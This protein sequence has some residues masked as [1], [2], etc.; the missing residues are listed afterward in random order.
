VDLRIARDD[1]PM[2]RALLTFEPRLQLHLVG[3]QL[4]ETADIRAVSRTDEVRQHVH[5]AERLAQDGRRRGRMGQRRPVGTG[6]FAASHRLAPQLA[7]TILGA[8]LGE[9]VDGEL[10]P[11][12][13]RLVQQLGGVVVARRQGHRRAMQLVIGAVRWC[14]PQLLQDLAQ[15]AGREARADDR[16]VQVGVE[17]PDFRPSRGSDGR[18]RFVA[19]D[20]SRRDRG[21][22]DEGLGDRAW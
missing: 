15:F 4:A 6:D 7:H 20:Q 8:D 3:L 16:T 12:V 10:V 14:Q 18:G 9:L 17:L 19:R 2:Q 21:R 13:Q 5:V 11:V 1:R 22:R